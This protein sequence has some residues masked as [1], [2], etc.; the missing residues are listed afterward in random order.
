MRSQAVIGS[1]NSILY[2]RPGCV[3]SLLLAAPLALLL[4]I[5]PAAMLDG[6]GGY[7]HT[8]LMLVM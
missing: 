4:L 3:L 7:D 2:R 5:H 6:A 1:V 8:R